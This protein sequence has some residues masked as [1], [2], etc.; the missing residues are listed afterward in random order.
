[1]KEL[2]SEIFS[3]T[4]ISEIFCYIVLKILQKQIWV[5]EYVFCGCELGIRKRN[6][7]LIFMEA[8]DKFQIFRSETVVPS[9]STTEKETEIFG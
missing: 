7:L 8:Q 4:V 5:L 6:P 3:C 2:I 1:M 9:I